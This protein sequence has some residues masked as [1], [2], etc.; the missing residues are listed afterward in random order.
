[1]QVNDLIQLT[2]YRYTKEVVICMEKMILNHL[3]WYLTVPTTYMF[4]VRFIKAAK[5]DKEVPHEII[6]SLIVW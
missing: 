5:A 6:Y 1:M 4:L 3:E 2:G